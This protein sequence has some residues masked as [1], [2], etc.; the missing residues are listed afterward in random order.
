MYVPGVCVRAAWGQA[1]RLPGH[2]V[3]REGR[4]HPEQLHFMSGTKQRLFQSP[5]QESLPCLSSGQLTAVR[6]NNTPPPLTVR[7][8]SVTTPCAGCPV[9]QVNPPYYVKLVELVPHPETAAVVMDTTRTLMTK[10]KRIKVNEGELFYI[11]NLPCFRSSRFPSVWGKRL[12]ALL[13]TGCR[14]L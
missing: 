8:M 5:E 1:E 13:S 6:L 7:L 10:V 4:C 11:D 12:T 2:R 9:L 14:L 3:P